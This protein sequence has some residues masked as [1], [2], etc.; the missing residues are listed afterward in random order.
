VPR[1]PRSLLRLLVLVA[2]TVLALA[3]CG[4]DSSSDADASSNGSS[5]G[6]GEDVTLRLGYFPNVTHAPALVGIQNE[7]FDENLPEGTTLELQDFNAGTD[8]VEAILAGSLD[9]SYI[10][11]NPAISLYAQDP[12]EIRIVSG[13]TSGGA[14]LVVNDEIES[15]EDL[16][17]KSI[18]SPSL[19]NTQDV[20]LRA[21]LLEEGYETTPEGGGDVTVVPQDNATTLTAFQAGDLDGAWVPEPWATRLIEEGGAHV[22]VDEAELW[23]DGEYVTTHV[24]VRTEFLEDHPDVVKG[25]LEGH[26]AAVASLADDAEAGAA[27]V[28]AQIEEATTQP[29]DVDL[30]TTTFENLTFTEDPV[31]SSLLVSAED[32]EE[33][34]LL[35]AVDL[36]GIYDLTLLNEI[37]GEQGKTEVSDT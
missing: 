34:G 32:A 25:L 14:F 10:G 16:A 29:V 24:I 30:I 8:V 7:L 20:A 18:A 6:S 12:S 19:G 17:G 11:P 1:S 13:A 23:P 22:L 37:L 4:D 9:A 3:A 21:W 5:G 36:E 27:A 2:V 35:D 15:P 28:S 33:L 31:A 26:V